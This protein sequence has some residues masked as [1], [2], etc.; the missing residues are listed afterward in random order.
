MRLLIEAI[1]LRYSYDFRDYSE[2]SQARRV[3]H[4]MVQMD[5][6]TVSELQSRV[7]HDEEAFARLLQYLTIPTSEMF[8]DP[9]YFLALREQVVPFLKTYPSLKIWIAGCSTGEEV[10]SM[11]I[12][13]H[14]EGLLERCI[15]YATDINPHSLD[16]A[17]KGVYPLDRMDHYAQSYRQAGGRA[18]LSDYYTAAYESALFD[19]ALLERVSFSDHSLATDSVFSETHLICCRNV[20]IYFNRQLQ[21]RA[22]GLFHE[23]LCHR[24]FLGLGSKE[25]IDFSGHANLFDPL[26][27][28]ER[29]YRK[30]ALEN[31]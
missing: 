21:E 31:A 12:L 23:S 8:R 9:S 15:L 2:A 6:R 27:R 26:V 5:C 25:S 1:Y 24:G 30:S 7:L 18:N 22:L 14:E 13:L 4:A 11:A 28:N 16:R 19:R 17:R 29:I 3:L 10:V 20:M